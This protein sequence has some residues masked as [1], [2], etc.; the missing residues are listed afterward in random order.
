[1]L[2][3]ILHD[4][5]SGPSKWFR[6]GITS[7]TLGLGALFLSAGSAFA[8][9]VDEVWETA[10]ALEDI[11]IINQAGATTGDGK[12]ERILG[13]FTSMTDWTYYT[14][15]GAMLHV[16]ITPRTNGANTDEILF[17][18]MRTGGSTSDL[19]DPIYPDGVDV[20]QSGN[21]S[22]SFNETDPVKDETITLW[23]DLLKVYSASDLQNK[24]LNGTPGELEFKWSDDVELHMAELD[25]HGT[26][27]PVPEP[28]SLLL[29][30]S[31]MIGLAAWRIRKGGKN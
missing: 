21:N 23:L 1:M 10:I 9:P 27:K 29:L 14:L 7:L 30:G 11:E 18:S 12:D 8:T 26:Y 13:T 4:T 24:L 19:Y 5:T 31:G 16:E 2:Q 25:L 22:R 17:G 6:T 20:F 15:T 28:G 3:N